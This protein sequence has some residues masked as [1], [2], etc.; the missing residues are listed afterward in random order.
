M[1][2][3]AFLVIER[4]FLPDQQYVLLIMTMHENSNDRRKKTWLSVR[5]MMG[6]AM[7]VVYLVVA[8]AVV[9][10]EKTGQIHI[11]TVI[12]YIIA[13]LMFLYGLFRIYRGYQQ[14]KGKA[15]Y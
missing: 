7:G 14:L 6:M 4:L 12:A 2:S 1:N 9:Y 15:F 13:S 3:G 5:G 10:L 11:G 8:L